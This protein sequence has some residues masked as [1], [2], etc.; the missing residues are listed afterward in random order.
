MSISFEE[1]LAEN[2]R[3]EAAKLATRFKSLKE[4]FYAWQGARE[5]KLLARV[6]HPEQ[7]VLFIEKTGSAQ[8]PS[9][10]GLPYYAD[11]EGYDTVRYGTVYY[12][13]HS[14]LKE[15][16]TVER[17]G[18]RWEVMMNHFSRGSAGSLAYQ[19]IY[20]LEVAQ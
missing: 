2:E 8:V 15:G 4:A 12:F 10:D 11:R 7:Q 1:W 16:D 17:D 13:H 19:C 14:T 3:Q 9:T 18:K 6:L 20:L 5:I